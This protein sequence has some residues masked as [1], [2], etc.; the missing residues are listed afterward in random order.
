MERCSRGEKMTT[1]IRT[2]LAGPIPDGHTLS[3]TFE[4]ENILLLIEEIAKKQEYYKDLKKHRVKS[5]DDKIGSLNEKE[6]ILRE[7]ILNTMK[8]M[9]EKSLD[10]PDIGKVSR[11][12][13]KSAIGIADQDTVVAYLDEKGLKD[14]VVKITESID[15][16]KLNSLIGDLE[17]QGEDV[18]G[19][20]KTE[21]KESLTVTFEKPKDPNTTVGA[22]ISTPTKS[23]LDL[24]DLDALL[25]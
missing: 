11:R 16:R 4:I 19:I 22:P 24:D 7:V 3:S 12:K 1:D 23:E 18:P 15:K 13:A 25:V 20:V 5:I 17:K 9:N 14:G 8:N 10:F 6:A 21:G 2:L